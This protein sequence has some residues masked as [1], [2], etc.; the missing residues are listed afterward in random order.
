VEVPTQVKAVT[1]SM[2]QSVGLLDKAVEV[3]RLWTKAREDRFVTRL[4]ALYSH[5][6]AEKQQAVADWN[7]QHQEQE[8]RQ[9][10]KRFEDDRVAILNSLY[11]RALASGQARALLP[12]SAKL[13]AAI[14]EQS[15]AAT[16]EPLVEDALAVIATLFSDDPAARGPALAQKVEAALRTATLPCPKVRAVANGAGGDPRPLAVRDALDQVIDD[17]KFPRAFEYDYLDDLDGILG[18]RYASGDLQ[19]QRSSRRMLDSVSLL[20]RAGG[21]EASRPLAARLKKILGDAH[22]YSPRR[23]APPPLVQRIIP[24][25]YEEFVS[26]RAVENPARFLEIN[27]EY[28]IRQRRVTGKWGPVGLSLLLGYERSHHAAL[29][30]LLALKNGGA[31]T[32][33]D[34]VLVVGPR[35]FDEIAFFRK[36]LNLPKTVGLD[37]FDAEGTVGGDMH[38]M[39]FD[40][41]RFRLIYCSGTLSYAYAI[42]QVFAEMLR[43]LKRPGYLLFTD[44]GERTNGVDALGR[45]DPV[46]ADAIIG[47]FH[48][49][50]FDVL[51]RDDGMSP[52]LDKFQQWPSVGLRIY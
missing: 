51:L 24:D 13:L 40:A 1:R 15:A 25:L 5:P 8:R 39:P 26:M 33:D 28:S 18:A 49:H 34:E 52:Y 38:A 46:S 16:R 50:Q 19:H 27:R 7:R 22:G 29:R 36:H 47:C 20:A 35:H 12:D 2:L 31:L 32:P 6:F 10:Q 44:A 17:Q 9:F 14:V 30:M 37:L 43:V 4:I 45:T 21:G 42:R 48:Q 3:T 23:S 11:Y 41:D